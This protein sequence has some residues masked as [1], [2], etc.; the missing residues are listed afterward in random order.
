VESSYSIGSSSAMFHTIIGCD[1]VPIFVVFVVK[2]MGGGD[3]GVH[4]TSRSIDYWSNKKEEE[5]ED[6]TTYCERSE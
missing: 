5:E 2:M 3:E 4:Y 1:L 6:A